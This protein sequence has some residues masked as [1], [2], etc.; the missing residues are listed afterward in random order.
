MEWRKQWD[1]VILVRQSM[2]I[3]CF[4]LTPKQAAYLFG[5]DLFPIPS[6]HICLYYNLILY[7]EFITETSFNS[8]MIYV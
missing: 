4:V 2:R 6:V 5:V 1:V 3:A 7:Q 8:M